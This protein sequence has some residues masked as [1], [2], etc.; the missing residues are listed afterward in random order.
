MGPIQPGG[1]ECLK[2]LFPCVGKAGPSLCVPPIG[3]MG[4]DVWDSIGATY[5]AF[6]PL[7]R[8]L[9]LLMGDG[10]KWARSP[11][12]SSGFSSSALG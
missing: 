6:V 8:V 1:S 4:K 2:T 7:V 3:Q 5:S 11:K 10:W 12:C 9:L